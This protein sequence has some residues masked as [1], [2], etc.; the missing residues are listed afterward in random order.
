MKGDVAIV[1]LARTPV[2]ISR[3]PGEFAVVEACP[4]R[5]EGKG[6]THVFLGFCAGFISSGCER[7][8]CRHFGCREKGHSKASGESQ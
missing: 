7:E 8:G 3:L 2:L 6:F 1:G 5:R 4:L